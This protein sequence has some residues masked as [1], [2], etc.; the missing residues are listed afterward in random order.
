[1]PSIEQI[2]TKLYKHY[3]GVAD[4]R[5]NRDFFEEAISSSFNV[6]PDQLWA[7]GDQVPRPTS[8]DEDSYKKVKAF[9]NGDVWTWQKDESTYIPVFTKYENYPLTKIDNG[10]D[11]SFKL[12][13]ENGNQIKN[14]IPFNYALDL[15]N[16]YLT[17][18]DGKRIYFGV[19]DWQ[20]DTFSGVLTFYGDL[21]EGVDHNHPPK[22]SFYQYT[23]GMGFRQDTY[24]YDGA[25]LP[26]ENWHVDKGVYVI[27]YNSN[28]NDN[29]LFYTISRLADKVELG[30]AGTY[31]WDG[32]DKNEG[33]ALS[34]EKIIALEYT[35]TKDKVKG[36][37]DSA[38]AEIGTLLSDKSASCSGPFNITFV[39]QGI[40]TTVT[41]E[42]VVENGQASF[43]GGKAKTITGGIYKLPN[44]TEDGFIVI[45]ADVM[46]PDDTYSVTVAE[47][48]VDTKALLLYWN[49]TTQEYLPFVTKDEFDGNF[50]FTIVAINGKIPPS[51]TMDSAAISA[52][53]DS[54]TPDYYGPRNYSVTVAVEGEYSTKSADYV[55]KNK[56][57]FYLKDII[58]RIISDFT[59]IEDGKEKLTFKGAI[60]LRAGTY[61]IPEDIDL[62]AF[63]T[64]AFLGEGSGNTVLKGNNVKFKYASKQN[65]FALFKEITFDGPSIEIDTKKTIV[66]IQNIV[67]SGSLYCSSSKNSVWITESS[68][69]KAISLTNDVDELEEPLNPGTIVCTLNHSI[70]GSLSVDAGH[71]AVSS[72]TANTAAFKEHE[73]VIVNNCFFQNVTEKPT[74]VQFRSCIVRHFA[75]T[76][77]RREIPN[78]GMFPI[79]SKSNDQYLQY[80]EFANHFTYDENLNSVSLNIDKDILCWKATADENVFELSCHIDA[81]QIKVDDVYE[82][83][84]NYDGEDTHT[85]ETLQGALIDL[86][87]TK[88]DLVSGKV[89]LTELPDSVA[90]G[91]LLYIGAWAFDVNNGEYPTFEGTMDEHPY[92]SLD[93]KVDDHKLQPGWFWVV[94]SSTQADIDN[95]VSDQN[96]VLQYKIVDGKVK[97]LATSLSPDVVAKIEKLTEADVN[98]LL[99]IE[100]PDDTSS[101][102]T[103][104]DI[105]SDIGS[106]TGSGSSISSI[107]GGN[108][109]K[110]RDYFLTGGLVFTA[111]DWI[112]WNGSYFEKLDRAYQDP[113]YS[114]LPVYTTGDN[115]DSSSGRIAW[116]WKCTRDIF[117]NGWGLGALDLGKKTIGEAFDQVNIELKRLQV[118]HPANISTLSLEPVKEY[119]TTDFRRVTNGVISG[120]VETAYDLNIDSTIKNFRVQTPRGEDWKSIFYFGDEAIITGYLDTEIESHEIK[121]KS[122][123]VEVQYDE[124]TGQPLTLMN[125]DKPF[126]PY[127]NEF[128]GQGYF[129]GTRADIGAKGDLDVG[130]HTFKIG[131][132]DVKPNNPVFMSGVVGA[133]SPYEIEVIKPYKLQKAAADDVASR[134]G[135]VNDTIEDAE[136]AGYCS[137]VKSI[138]MK[139]E[140]FTFNLTYRIKAA[141]GDC[142][143]ID[144]DKL[145]KVYSNI[146]PT[147]QTPQFSISSNID[148]MDGL[149]DYV[150]YRD[151]YSVHNDGVYTNFAVN[152][153]IYDVYGNEKR[154][155]NIFNYPIRFDPTTETER[156]FSGGELFPP[157]NPD[158][159]TFCGNSEWDS[160]ASLKDDVYIYELQKVGRNVTVGDKTRAISEY[161]WP[162][163][164]YY[165]FDPTKS[166]SYT[167][168]QSGVVINEDTYRFVTL[169]QFG[170]DEDHLSEVILDSNSGF[171]MRFHVADDALDAW[172]V[173][174]YSMTTNNLI[175]QAKIIYPNATSGDPSLTKW[176][177]CNSPY[178]GFLKVGD[179]EG[180]DGDPA[181]YAGKSN[182]TRK[183]ITFGRSIYSGK[184]II[185]VGIKKGSNLSFRTI[186]IEDLI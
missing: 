89:P 44:A 183:R 77:N 33:I 171:T 120:E 13:D 22:I 80:A 93:L 69:E 179:M 57:G 117:E 181:M 23:G 26:I 133:T 131:V 11:K 161:K 155:N 116:F 41:H 132:S 53:S 146:D 29:S 75:A 101:S 186:S 68:F 157:Y 32:A 107:I 84:K 168:V 73:D 30:F 19:G 15:Y 160:S 38:D 143:N 60:F 31:G 82:R 148:G 136:I 70:G 21:P 100:N 150:M 37:D 16:Y 45:E 108:S 52:Y 65:G 172:T 99:N 14:I 130:K 154:F 138:K 12:V 125:I 17:T 126:D 3:S 39:S 176:I 95:P 113:V 79:Y 98:A 162:D 134:K 81:G 67:S 28:D 159:R 91:G 185:R 152:A 9:K 96:T 112:I 102:D 163:G 105:G 36:Y 10:T 51:V 27:K 49:K 123:A 103:G 139:K 122:E 18:D 40:D 184:L 78:V 64:F 156:V 111:G 72:I 174:P 83:D 88:A 180:E 1:M 149:Y 54:I 182:A 43:D 66:I 119:L 121:T 151:A 165:E 2:T 135:L 144:N 173:D 24:G 141:I 50:G 128:A 7:Y 115:S 76:I 92:L 158:K 85:G 104:S 56:T 8:P 97:V 61:E 59:I 178:D 63:S 164:I 153:V 71:V 124:E 94:A 114:I 87:K 145:I 42:I 20:L 170:L 169:T 58:N 166:L 147:L 118:K 35:F 46:I 90:Y 62:S 25:T 48:P 5:T 6:R 106:D 34:L 129:Y 55:V 74:V 86:Y 140:P 167:N 175:I 137:G 47:N 142:V 177:D 109:D 4:S 110:F 127:V